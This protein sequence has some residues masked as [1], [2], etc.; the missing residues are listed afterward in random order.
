MNLQV[1][2]LSDF[3]GSVRETARE[4][5][6]G[7]RVTSK[8]R[9]WVAPEDFVQLVRPERIQLIRYLR[10]KNHVLFS[11]LVADLHR[12]AASLRRDVKLL[13]KYQ[14]VQVIRGNTT[15]KGICNVIEPTFGTQAI[16]INAEI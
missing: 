5:D 14:L 15:E 1:G 12:S 13:V 6:N 2:T 10:G 11:D 8:H 4:L 16:E 3:F 9:V 7:R